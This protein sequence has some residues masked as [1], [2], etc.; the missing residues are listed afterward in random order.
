[1]KKGMYGICIAALIALSAINADVANKSEGTSRGK[2]FISKIAKTLTLRNGE[3]PTPTKKIVYSYDDA[4]NRI[5]RQVVM[6]KSSQSTA[7][8][9]KIAV[10][11]TK[12]SATSASMTKAAVSGEGKTGATVSAEI[13]MEVSI[14]PNPTQ[15]VFQVDISGTDIPQG[16][17]IEIY[18]GSGALAGRWTDISYNNTFDISDKPAGIYIL[19]LTLGKECIKT[20]KIIKN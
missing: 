6:P 16:A 11:E 19:R 15:G 12:E 5:N 1:M 3:A 8:S 9:T 4:G 20:L 13:Q 17:Q 2:S 10:T 14:Y 7:D 18:S